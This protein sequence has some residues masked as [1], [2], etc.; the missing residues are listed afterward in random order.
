MLNS[1]LEMLERGLEI[2]E[3]RHGVDSHSAKMFRKQIAEEKAAIKANLKDQPLTYLAKT[4]PSGSLPT[5][6]QEKIF[7]KGLEMKDDTGTSPEETAPQTD[8]G[9]DGLQVN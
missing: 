3:E 2:A 5:S 6:L 4:L 9:I 8:Q 7:E 1:R